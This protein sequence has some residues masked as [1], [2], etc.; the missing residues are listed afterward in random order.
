MWK[1]AYTI[2]TISVLS[3][4]TRQQDASD[5]ITPSFSRAST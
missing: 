2:A 4:R 3:H 5:A 1:T